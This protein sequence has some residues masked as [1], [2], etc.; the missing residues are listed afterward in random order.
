MP[1]K[2]INLVAADMGYGHQRAAYP[3]LT[4]GKEILTINNYH[5]IPSWE[6][7]QWLKNLEAYERISRF[8]KVPIVGK[9]VFATMDYF[10]RIKPL[11]PFRNLSGKTSQQKYFLQLIK[12][13]LGKDLIDKLSLSNLPLVT[14]FFV[15]AYMADYHQYK[16]DVYCIICDADVS[17]A[18]APIDP[19]N[20]RVKY[21]APNEQVKKRLMMYGVLEKNIIISGFPLP[22]ENTG[23]Q[24]EIVKFDLENRLRLLDPNNIYRQKE[25]PLL[26]KIV[27]GCLEDVKLKRPLTITFAV[28][29]AGAQKEIGAAILNKLSSWVKE[30]RLN[31]NLVAG[32][33]AEV[34]S[35]FQIKINEAG[36]NDNRGVK[37]IFNK[38]KID[39]F[40]NFNKVLRQTD[41]LWT[42]PSELSFYSGLGLPIMMSEPVGSQ[43]V[44]NRAW[45]ISIGAGVDSQDYRYV[46][47]WLPDMLNSGQLAR[48]A[49]DGFLNA[50]NMG[51]YNIAKCLGVKKL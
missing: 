6:K 25:K 4:I 11:Y 16:G 10:Q 28:G 38:K 9:A 51:T 20:S 31:I 40:K 7:Q 19:K 29:G 50:E 2:K 43:E 18:W 45:L 5:G 34:A 1:D 35:Y 42:K 46:D 47:E 30:G 23:A 41:I 8:K 12:K 32:N 14:T 21:F 26:K 44:F 15:V 48:A 27:P 33:R 22:L 17:R 37:I 13:G 49:M 3:L 24:Q 36:L 39:Y